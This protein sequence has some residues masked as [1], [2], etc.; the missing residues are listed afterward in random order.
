[1][2]RNGSGTYSLPAGNP[3]VTGTT[4]SSTWANTTLADIATALTNSVASDGQ[5][6]MS[7]N[8]QLGNNK[9]VNVGNGTN[10]GDAVNYGQLLASAG[11]TGR[12]VQIVQSRNGSYSATS[13][14]SYASTGHTATITPTS[15]TSKIIVMLSSYF[16]QTNLNNGNAYLTI[17]RNGTDICGGA[18]FVQQNASTSG[19]SSGIYG[20]MS[21]QFVDSPATT[22]A[23]TYEP[24]IR[25]DSSGNA[26]YNGAGTGTLI[27]LEISQ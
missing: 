5:T 21:Y 19:A 27:L 26:A 10:S 9:I 2:S 20:S 18:A 8:L 22:S 13:S 16:W 12:L 11:G 17:F 25:V 7:G 14:T 4:I 3:V 1:M 24:R 23:L 15:A 6:T